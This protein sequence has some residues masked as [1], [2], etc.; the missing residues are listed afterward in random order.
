MKSK[1]K[2]ILFILIAIIVLYFIRNN[3]KDYNLKRTISACI[4]AQKQNS[5]TFD[6]EKAKTFCEKKI[7]QN[8]KFSE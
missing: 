5:E 3:Y 2:I 1:T 4:F 8:L 6:L 7:K